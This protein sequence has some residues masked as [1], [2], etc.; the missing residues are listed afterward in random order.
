MREYHQKYLT[1]TLLGIATIIGC[2]SADDVKTDTVVV[3]HRKQWPQKC[4][5]CGAEWIVVPNDPSEPVPPT[6]EWCFN[7]GSYCEEGFEIILDQLKNGRSEELDRRWLNHCLKCKSCRC[8]AFTPEKWHKITDA[9]KAM[10][11]N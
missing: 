11:Q 9:I 6:V 4:E 2:S 5:M 3:V 10:R 8:A 1:Y 7:D